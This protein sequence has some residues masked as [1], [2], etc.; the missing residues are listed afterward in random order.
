MIVL[1]QDLPD[2]ILS[3]IL[4]EGIEG[5]HPY[6]KKAIRLVCKLWKELSDSTTTALCISGLR[7]IPKK[8]AARFTAVERVTIKK[9]L[10]ATCLQTLQK[11]PAL[12]TIQFQP[13]NRRLRADYLAPLQ[14]M[15]RLRTVLFPPSYETEANVN[16][17]HVLQLRGL[18]LTKL[19][20]Q[21]SCITDKGLEGLRG[22]PLS[23]LELESDL[24]TDKGL[25][26]LQGMP[27]VHLN[28]KHCDI[29]DAGMQFLRGMP[30]AEL[31]LG[32]HDCRISDE[33]LEV[34]RGMPLVF[35]SL[36]RC[37]CLTDA[38]WMVLRDLPD[39][40]V[41]VVQECGT[42]SSYKGIAGLER[43]GLKI[44]FERTEPDWDED[45]NGPYH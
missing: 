35:L 1:L 24:V 34:L 19:S 31:Y 38:A 3:K 33:G 18:P 8:W 7:K 12:T 44:Y 10:S 29:Q 23:W 4:S 30:L 41:L 37:D 40:K 2:D 11:L 42:M 45:Y 22:M 36:Q 5:T 14:D 13:I 39:L 17:A 27:L 9:G 32:Y 16:D 6:T 28:L 26:V 43:V 20:L 21:S 25:A 15:Q